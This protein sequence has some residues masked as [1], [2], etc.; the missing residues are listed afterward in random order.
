MSDVD[1]REWYTSP[2]HHPAAHQLPPTV[3]DNPGPLMFVLTSA[4]EAQQRIEK[5]AETDLY[6][7]CVARVLGILYTQVTL[8]QRDAAKNLA[9][10]VAYSKN[11]TETD[12]LV[13]EAQRALGMDPAAERVCKALQPFASLLRNPK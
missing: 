11:A 1:W 4:A 3:P 2:Y 7:R 6:T 13:E 9:F 5:M 10:T 12:P 8:K